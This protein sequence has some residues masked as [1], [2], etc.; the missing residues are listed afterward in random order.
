M[1]VLHYYYYQNYFHCD[2]RENLLKIT[3]LPND[4]LHN[5]LC[6]QYLFKK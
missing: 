6:T 4:I 2:K 3:P 1:H 5:Y